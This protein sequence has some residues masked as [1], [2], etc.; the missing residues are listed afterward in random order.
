MC[1]RSTPGVGLLPGFS[2]SELVIQVL[3]LPVAPLR[4][5]QPP[6]LQGGC[7]AEGEEHPCSRAWLRAP[8]W[9]PA[10]LQSC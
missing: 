1:R 8:G 7:S 5:L 2:H 10:V 6:R 3:T 4:T 9:K